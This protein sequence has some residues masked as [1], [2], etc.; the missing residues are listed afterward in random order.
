MKNTKKF[1]LI[2]GLTLSG[3]GMDITPNVSFSGEKDGE[4]EDF[5]KTNVNFS[6]EKDGESEDFLKKDEGSFTKSSKKSKWIYNYG[7]SSPSKLTAPNPKDGLTCDSTGCDFFVQ[8]LVGTNGIEK[9][10]SVSA[11]LLP[12]SSSEDKIPIKNSFIDNHAIRVP[13]CPEGVKPLA[14]VQNPK[15]RFYELKTRVQPGLYLLMTDTILDNGGGGGS[16]G[17]IDIQSSAQKL[18]SAE[19]HNCSLTGLEAF[20]IVT[21]DHDSNNGANNRKPEVKVDQGEIACQY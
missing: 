20:G 6:G 8:L 10:K 3:C 19:G 4:S 2:M 16:G 11:C 15:T 13:S 14:F 9:V 17:P 12:L 5:L 7:A 21:E 1:T 18:V